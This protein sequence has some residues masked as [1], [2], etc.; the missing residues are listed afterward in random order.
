MRIGKRHAGCTL[1]NYRVDDNNR[2]AYK[3]CV[4][5]SKKPTSVILSGSVGTGKTHLLTAVARMVEHNN[6]GKGMWRVQFWPMLDLVLKLRQNYDDSES[7]IECLNRAPLLVLDD[8]GAER[9]TDY[10]LETIEAVVDYRY[11]QCRPTLVGTNLTLEELSERYRDRVLSRWM[12]DGGFIRIAG[13]DKRLER[14]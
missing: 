1:E 6:Q 7:L 8:L 3:A 9:T 11:R 13:K 2:E 12:G 4:A 10:I 14:T 5:I